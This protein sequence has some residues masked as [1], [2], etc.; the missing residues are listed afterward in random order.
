MASVR[1]PLKV[2][3]HRSP[4]RTASRCLAEELEPLAAEDVHVH[5]RCKQ[6]RVRRGQVIGG[7]T[8][9]P[10]AGHLWHLCERPHRERRAADYRDWGRREHEPLA[11]EPFQASEVFD[12]RDSGF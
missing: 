9:P 4:R 1:L 6:R 2:T 5:E 12:D 11:R 10:Q 3:A 8:A 7:P